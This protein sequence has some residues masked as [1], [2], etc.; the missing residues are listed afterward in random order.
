MQKQPLLG[1]AKPAPRQPGAMAGGT[2]GSAGWAE[3]S[4]LL[5]HPNLSLLERIWPPEAICWDKGRLYKLAIYYQMLSAAPALRQ[6]VMDPN[7]LIPQTK[8]HNL[9]KSEGSPFGAPTC[10]HT[11]CESCLPELSSIFPSV[12]GCFPILEMVWG[13]D[14]EL[15]ITGW[16]RLGS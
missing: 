1:E 3:S 5:P 2:Q 7:K 6:S 13:G 9:P 4:P 10:G 14:W 11:A 15:M 8:C 16:R 12:W